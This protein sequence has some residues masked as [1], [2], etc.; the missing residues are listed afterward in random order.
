MVRILMDASLEA[1]LRK[2]L[3]LSSIAPSIAHRPEMHVLVVRLQYPAW[4]C[5]AHHDAVLHWP[6]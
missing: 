1:C 2:S 3:M 4:H 5:H 6:S